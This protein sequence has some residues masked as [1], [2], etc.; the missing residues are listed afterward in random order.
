MVSEIWG[1]AQRGI[2][3][4]RQ[5]LKHQKKDKKGREEHILP[6]KKKNAMRCC[7]GNTSRQ[8]RVKELGAIHGGKGEGMRGK[9]RNDRQKARMEGKLPV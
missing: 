6:S 4:L 2:I 3:W 9:L 8:I 5:L 7:S 1:G